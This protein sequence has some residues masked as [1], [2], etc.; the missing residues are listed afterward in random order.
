MHYISLNTFSNP[1][2]IMFHRITEKTKASGLCKGDVVII[3]RDLIAGDADLKMY[4]DQEDRRYFVTKR[5]MRTKKYWG[6]VSWILKS[7]RNLEL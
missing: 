2:K 1:S 5:E 7:P 6:K 4:F 3:E